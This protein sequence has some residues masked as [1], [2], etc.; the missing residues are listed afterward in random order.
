MYEKLDD[1]LDY[2]NSRHRLE[3][4]LLMPVDQLTRLKRLGMTPSYHINHLLFYGD[5]LKEHVV[6][7]ERAKQ[8]LPLQSTLEQGL[9]LTLHADQPM[10]KSDPLRL[11]Q[12]AVQRETQSGQTINAEQQI[13]IQDALKAMTIDAAWQIR[14]E[15]KLG[16]LSIG[17]YADFIILD[18]NPLQAEVSDLHTINCLETYVAGNRVAT[19]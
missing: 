1:K 15:D 8:L 19:D 2:S 7:E 11:I 6:G 18:R 16:S 14:K 13:T 9:K 12:T 3:H 10:F 17:K 5:A 4:C